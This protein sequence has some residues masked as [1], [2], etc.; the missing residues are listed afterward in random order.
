MQSLDVQQEEKRSV[1]EAKFG[2]ITEKR[3][4]VLRSQVCVSV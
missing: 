2:G 3:F 1:T 4:I